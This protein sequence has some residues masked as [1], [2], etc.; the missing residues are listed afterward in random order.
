MSNNGNQNK[1]GK[2]QKSTALKKIRDGDYGGRMNVRI[3][4]GE[5]YYKETSRVKTLDD[6][7]RKK[8]AS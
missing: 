1:S 8:S 2:A 3:P 5:E 4:T 6:I 7:A